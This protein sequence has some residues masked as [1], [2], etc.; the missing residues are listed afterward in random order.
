MNPSEDYIFTQEEPYRSILMHLQ[1]VINATI[2]EVELKFKYKVPFFYVEKRPI[3]YIHRPKGKDYVDLGFW[4]AVHLTVNLEYMTT[5]GRKVMKSLRYKS[6]DD[7][8][9]SI[10]TEILINAYVV[11]DKKF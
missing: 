5:A 1:Y 2:P 7:I 6:L 10:L 4:N 3:C 9:N 11:K 8:D